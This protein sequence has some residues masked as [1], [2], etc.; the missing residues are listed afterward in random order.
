MIAS[1]PESKYLM[2]YSTVKISIHKHNKERKKKED[3]T[4]LLILHRT[5][6]DGNFVFGARY[7]NFSLWQALIAHLFRIVCAGES[8]SLMKLN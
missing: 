2:I 1:Q 8:F 6:V 3:V 5:Y 4:T 7:I